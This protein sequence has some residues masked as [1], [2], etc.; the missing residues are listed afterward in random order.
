MRRSTSLVL[1][2][3]LALSALVPLLLGCGAKTE[4]GTFYMYQ[5][6]GTGR[7]QEPLSLLPPDQ[8]SA[9]QMPKQEIREETGKAFV[10]LA[11][12]HKILAECPFLDLKE[13]Q[14]VSVQQNANGSWVVVSVADK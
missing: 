11:N 7:Y 5:T 1:C 9:L 6:Q 13:K 10:I 14:P 12:G 8:D 4:R 3:L 2:L